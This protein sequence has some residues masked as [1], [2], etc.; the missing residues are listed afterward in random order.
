MSS[1]GKSFRFV[2][3]ARASVRAAANPSRFGLNSMLTSLLFVFSSLVML[4]FPAFFVNPHRNPSPS[5]QLLLALSVKGS[6]SSGYIPTTSAYPLLIVVSDIAKK[7][8]KH[9]CRHRSEMA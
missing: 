1:T 7:G 9:I 5:I 6:V 2:L 3:C 4:L 8:T